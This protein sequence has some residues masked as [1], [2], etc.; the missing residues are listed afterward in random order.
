MVGFVRGAAVA[1]APPTLDPTQRAV[2]DL[3]DAASAAVLGAPGTGKTTTLVELVADRVLGRGWHPSRC[4]R[5]RR[6]ARPRP[7]CATRSPCASA[8][9]TTGPMARTVNSLAFEIVGDAARAAGAVPPRLVTGGEQDADIAGL[10]EGH[11]EDGSGPAWPASLGAEVRAHPA[12]PIGV[13]RAHDACDRVRRVAGRPARARAHPRAARV[14]G[15]RGLHGRVLPGGHGV[16]RAAARPGRARAV[17]VGGDSQRAS[18]RPGRGA[19]ACRRRRL[20]GVDGGHVPDP[21]GAREP[22]HRT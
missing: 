12:L 11:L 19:A 20:P 15:I 9:P 13:A 2:V 6:S 17:R 22:R 4:S 7:A 8:V 14:G 5:S 18:W 3:P 21:A 1:S 10:L 16:A